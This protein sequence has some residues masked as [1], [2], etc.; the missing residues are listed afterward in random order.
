MSNEMR[1]SFRDRSRR[2]VRNTMHDES[3]RELIVIFLN[4]MMLG[5][6]EVLLHFLTAKVLQ[7][8]QKPD[9][10]SLCCPSASATTVAVD[11]PAVPVG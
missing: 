5:K 4:G 3:T 9:T 8:R 6:Q 7:G 11:F 10:C 2:Y 1:V